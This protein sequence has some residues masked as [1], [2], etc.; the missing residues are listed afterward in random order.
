M[1]NKEELKKKLTP[2]QY[3]VTQERKDRLKIL[4]GIA[5]SKDFMWISF[6]ANRFFQA[7]ISLIQVADGQAS[8]DRLIDFKPRLIEHMECLEQKLE[9]KKLTAI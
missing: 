9:A 1:I 3:H 4:F 5:I 7:W 2:I 6:Q 8:Q